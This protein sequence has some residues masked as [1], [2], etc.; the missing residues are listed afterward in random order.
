MHRSRALCMSAPAVHVIW[1]VCSCIIWYSKLHH[2]PVSGAPRPHDTSKTHSRDQQVSG[3]L[4]WLRKVWLIAS[5]NCRMMN[6][7]QFADWLETGRVGC[8]MSECVCS[9]WIVITTFV[10]RHILAK[11]WVRMTHNKNIF[12][13][14]CIQRAAAYNT[15]RSS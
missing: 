14:V 3:E 11:L 5:R 7:D 9:E 10:T 15:A 1:I 4:F 8:G 13:H 12:S 2:Q 6:V